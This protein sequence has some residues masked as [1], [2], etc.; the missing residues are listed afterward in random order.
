MVSWGY[1]GGW[2]ENSQ[3]MKCMSCGVGVQ[4]ES[5]WSPVGVQL[6]SGFVWTFSNYVVFSRSC[7][8][9]ICSCVCLPACF[10]SLSSVHLHVWLSGCLVVWLFGCVFVCFCC[11]VLVSYAVMY[12]WVSAWVNEWVREWMSE[13][14]SQSVS[15]SVS[16]SVSQ[17][18]SQSISQ[19]VGR[20]VNQVIS[21]WINQSCV[22]ENKSFGWALHMTGTP[23]IWIDQS[24][25]SRQEKL[26]CTYVKYMLTRRTLK[27]ATFSD[28]RRHWIFTE[29]TFIILKKYQAFKPEKYEN[30]WLEAFNLARNM[31]HL[32]PAASS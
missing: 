3:C 23:G 16:E 20:S 2:I 17:W 1:E 6:E 27:S 12:K 8:R 30:I 26:Y 31:D 19:L 14:F 15:Q 28:W 7:Q 25:F 13:L 5:S 4:L 22:D 24:G 21:Q 11:F 9:F 10:L 32:R 18:V 29:K